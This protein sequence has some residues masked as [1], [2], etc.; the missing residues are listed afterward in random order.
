MDEELE[1]FGVGENDTDIDVLVSYTLCVFG[2]I[3]L[4]IYI[5][6]YRLLLTLLSSPSNSTNSNRHKILVLLTFLMKLKRNTSQRNKP[7]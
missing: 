2:S 6:R 4:I 7:W 3:P 5:R 1:K